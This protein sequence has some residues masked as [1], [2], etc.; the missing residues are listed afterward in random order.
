MS[1]DSTLSPEAEDQEYLLDR[2]LRNDRGLR[3]ASITNNQRDY[4]FSKRQA[5]G[6]LAQSGELL[7]AARMPDGVIKIGWTANLQRRAAAFPAGFQ[8]LAIK[9]GTRA[10]ELAVHRSLAGHA[11]Q[12][13]EWYPPIPEVLAVVNDW[14]EALGREPIAA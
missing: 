1:E 14:R 6:I 10:D 8:F 12:G 4:P 3:L 11:V 2:R 5:M 9:P 13:R 7:Y